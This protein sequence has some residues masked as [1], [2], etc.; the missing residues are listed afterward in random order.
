MHRSLLCLALLL[1]LAATATAIEPPGSYHF[2]RR[3]IA[4]LYPIYQRPVYYYYPAAAARG[5][6]RPYYGPVVGLR[7]YAL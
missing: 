7:W 4:E 6:A 3:P 5:R 2:Q 1:T